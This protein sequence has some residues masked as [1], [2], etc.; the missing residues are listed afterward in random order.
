MVLWDS[1]FQLSADFQGEVVSWEKNLIR[2]TGC[3][4]WSPSLKPEVLTYSDASDSGADLLFRSGDKQ[5]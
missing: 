3:P 1:P 5:Q 2:N 4:I